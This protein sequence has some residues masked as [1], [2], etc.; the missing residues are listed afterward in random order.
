M[1]GLRPLVVKSYI[2]VA[3]HI[4]PEF[5]EPSRVLAIRKMAQTAEPVLDRF[6]PEKFGRLLDRMVF[7]DLRRSS[8]EE[9]FRIADKIDVDVGVNIGAARLEMPIYVGDMSFGALSGNPNIAIAK[10]VT[11]VGAVAGVGEGGLHP[12]VAKYRNIV[13]QWA[14]ARFGMD[15]NLLRAGIAVN[16]KIG[17]GAKPGIGGHLPG[18]KVVDIIAQLRKI[19]V[20]SEAISPAPHHDIYSIEDLAQRVKALRDLTKKPVLVKVAAVNK[21]HYVSVGVARST[22]EGIIIDGA[23]AGT[24]ATP[25]VARDHL[26]IPIDIAVPVV[27]QWLRKDGT[28]SGFLV[29]AGGMLY[30]PL[31]VAKIAALGAD[32]A[33]LGTASL[34]A[35]GCIMCH[36]CH[37]GGC[38]TA[39]TNMIGSGKELDIEWGSSVLRNY[40]LAVA[41]GLKAVLYSL[42]MSSIKELV[43]R[44]DLLQIHHVD[45]DLADAIGVELGQPGDAAWFDK[46]R[47]VVV[48]RE[49]YESV[50]IPITGMGGVVPGY[51]T[52]ARRLLDVLRIEAAQVTR[53]SVDPYREDVDVSVR[54]GDVTF[55]TPIA[56]PA[57]D[58]AVEDAAYVM[59]APILADR[60]RYGEYCI[61]ALNPAVI[62]PSDADVGPGVV[63]IDERLGGD[64]PLEAAVAR[65]HRRLMESGRRN[66]TLIVAVGDL[67]NGAD[68]YK[69]AALGADIV[70]PLSAF[71]YVSQRV[72]DMP[73]GERRCRYENLIAN[74]TAELKV[75]MGAGGVTSY[76]HT[77]VGNLD[78]LR[79][80]D[81]R[82]GRLLGVEVAGR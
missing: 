25:I 32:M 39:L 38:P 45:E 58:E 63:V 40:L 16:I 18:R 24:G 77:L 19:P 48:P 11:E 17:Q 49:Y 55:D 33:N 35:M 56:A 78:L 7:R 41:R 13:V 76:M 6:E 37:T 28:R 70:A 59:G 50:H 36:A 12:E 69:T 82:V 26:G 4:V 68:V 67:Y 5:W 30:S 1:S 79:S 46:T 64:L 23:G 71:Q 31:D 3:R 22:A 47:R 62:P 60:C 72:K 65:L 74:L 9:A 34:L 43:G 54:F 61:G 15:M 53:P 75:L 20:G 27:D 51:T 57:V 29:V 21:I 8:L 10:A 42:G 2:E 66:K 14:S 44:R 81:G 73:K 52:P 80:L